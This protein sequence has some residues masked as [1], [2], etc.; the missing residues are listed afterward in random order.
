M[1][2]KTQPRTTP[3]VIPFTPCFAILQL[4]VKMADEAMCVGP[5]PTNQSYLNM[6]AIL[7]VIKTTGAQA[8]SERILNL[9]L[10]WN[11]SRVTVEL[12]RQSLLFLGRAFS[13]TTIYRMVL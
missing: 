12:G 6:E 9:N 1:L 7:D 2:W 3:Q 13:K 10:L 11:K 8:V 5:P 4:H